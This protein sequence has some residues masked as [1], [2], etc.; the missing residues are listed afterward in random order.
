MENTLLLLTNAS[1]MANS[2][3]P[4]VIVLIIFFENENQYKSPG[5]Y[6]I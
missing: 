4:S 3:T 1:P 6:K 5:Q 2:D